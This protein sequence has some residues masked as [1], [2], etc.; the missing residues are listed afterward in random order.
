MTPEMYVVGSIVLAVIMV[1][2]LYLF[3]GHVPV[4]LKCP[5]CGATMQIV[6]DEL[7]G[8]VK[9]FQVVPAVRKLQCPQCGYSERSWAC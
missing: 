6:G 9:R 5:R 7:E 1:A 2:V 3:G 4:A 8:W